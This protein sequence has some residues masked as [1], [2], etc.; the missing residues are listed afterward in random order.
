MFGLFLA[1]NRK[2]HIACTKNG[3]DLE[4]IRKYF[5]R[6]RIFAIQQLDLGK[7]TSVIILFFRK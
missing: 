6:K 5:R 1:K 4:K 2:E 3:I 7:Q